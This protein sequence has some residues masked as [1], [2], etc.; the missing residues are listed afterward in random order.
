MAVSQATLQCNL[1]VC[2]YGRCYHDNK[3]CLYHGRGVRWGRSKRTRYVWTQDIC[4]YIIHYTH[5]V[6]R[7]TYASLT[8]YSY[9][10]DFNIELN[11]LLASWELDLAEGK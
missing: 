5:S 8:R 10:N 9:F 7:C 4:I 11:W 1:A 3:T 2:G 6:T